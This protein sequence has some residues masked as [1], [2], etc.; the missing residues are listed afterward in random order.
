MRVGG[1][2]TLEAHLFLPFRRLW[3]Y[4]VLAY[5]CEGHPIMETAQLST[6]K[7]TEIIILVITLIGQLLSFNI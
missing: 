5:G 6:T 1:L 7:H 2:I 4:T 3:N